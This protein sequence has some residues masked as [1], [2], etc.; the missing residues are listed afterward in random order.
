MHVWET[1]IHRQ[2]KPILSFQVVL[3]RAIMT[4]LQEKLKRCQ[5]IPNFHFICQFIETHGFPQ[6]SL[7]LTCCP[8]QHEYAS[9]ALLAAVVMAGH[10]FLLSHQPFS[11]SLPSR[12]RLW[13]ASY[14]IS[15]LNISLPSLLILLSCPP[16]TDLLSCK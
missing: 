16:T 8:Q 9:Q 15:L 3:H 7:S 10:P 4:W 2:S 1:G 6:A 5:S 13:N 11:P 14:K 12:P